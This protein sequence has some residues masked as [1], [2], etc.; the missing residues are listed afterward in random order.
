M[1]KIATIINQDRII[2]SHTIL[3]VEEA[4]IYE[5]KHAA[6]GYRLLSRD[7]NDANFV[8]AV[9]E[10]FDPECVDV[11]RWLIEAVY[12]AKRFRKLKGFNISKELYKAAEYV[13]AASNTEEGDMRTVEFINTHCK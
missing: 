10:A 11:S 4:R 9:K 1:L 3:E 8:A 2:I 12:E 13:Y 5:M 6:F 7:L